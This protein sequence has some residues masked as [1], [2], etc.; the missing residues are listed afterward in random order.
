MNISFLFNGDRLRRI[1]LWFYECSSQR[2]AHEALARVVEYLQRTAGGVAIGA[3]PGTK[4]T[5]DLI[6]EMLTGAAVQPGRVVHFEICTPA[7]PKPEVWFSRVGRHEQGYMVI[8]FAD[9][10]EG[11]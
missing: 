8:L 11:A 9:A 3:L 7:G 10:R 2:E 5:P 1:Q 4:V 6:M